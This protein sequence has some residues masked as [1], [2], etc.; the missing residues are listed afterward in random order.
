MSDWKGWSRIVRAALALSALVHCASGAAADQSVSCCRDLED[1]I[2]ELEATTAHKGNRKVSLEVSG[3]VNQAIMYWDDGFE[4]NAYVVT[5]DSSRTHLRFEGSAKLSRGW[6]AGYRLEFGFRTANSK[7]FTQDDPTAAENSG[8]DLRYSVWHLKNDALGRL[9][10]G[11]TGGASDGVTEM[12]VAQ[13][14]TVAKYSDQEDIGLGLAMR[15]DTGLYDNGTTVAAGT[16]TWRR[17]IRDYGTQPGEGRRTNMIKYDSPTWHG[18]KAIANWGEDDFW[19]AGL[20]YASETAGFKLAAGAAYGENV[21]LKTSS[22]QVGFECLA[23]NANGIPPG[24]GT[25][26]KCRQWGGSVSAMHLESG[27]YVN[28]AAGLAHDDLIRLAGA[29]FA[30][31]DPDSTFWALESGIERRWLALGKTTLF[32]QYYDLDGGASARRT[33]AGEPILATG[34]TS[35]GG[36]IVQAIDPAAMQLYA[37]ARHYDGSVTTTAGRPNLVPLD[38]VTVGAIIKF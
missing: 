31:A 30:N 8:I 10:L 17:L 23:Q 36:G 34:L 33:F 19:E 6:E 27:L 28:F 7:R 35:Y 25:D 5:N 1:R 21:E 2:A 29:A 24:S 14:G 22:G 20:R 37:F 11:L 26:A 18:F 32:G 38:I 13:T 16:F 15:L 12:D 9:S 3:Q 4:Q